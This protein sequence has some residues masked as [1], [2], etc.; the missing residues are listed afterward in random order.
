MTNL[1]FGCYFD[2]EIKPNVLPEGLTDLTFGYRFDK[3]IKPNVL[4]EGLTQLKL[5]PKVKFVNP[6]GKTSGSSSTLKL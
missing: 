4:P 5:Y 1:T 3:E 2:K 6:S